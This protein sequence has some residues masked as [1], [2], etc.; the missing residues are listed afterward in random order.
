M[1]PKTFMI[2]CKEA[3]L[4]I[5]KKEENKLSVSER[6]KLFVHLLICKLCKFFY[7]QNQFL[8]VEMKRLHTNASLS[9]LD[10]KNLEQLIEKET[11]KK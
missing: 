9:T 4:Y 1:I 11:S 10:K 2:T 5:S 6:F 3:T 8:A 7:R